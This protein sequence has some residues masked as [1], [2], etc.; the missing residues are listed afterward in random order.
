MFDSLKSLTPAMQSK[1]WKEAV[2]RQDY[3]YPKHGERESRFSSTSV[4]RAEYEPNRPE[5]GLGRVRMAKSGY[6]GFVPAKQCENIHGKTFQDVTSTASRCIKERANRDEPR[7]VSECLVP[8]SPAHRSCSAP[9]LSPTTGFESSSPSV[10]RNPRGTEVLRAGG[11]IP[12]YAGFIPGKAAGGVFG[13][14]VP[15]A[16]MQAMQVRQGRYGG[17]PS[18]SNWIVHGEND[19]RETIYGSSLTGD[20]WRSKTMSTTTSQLLPSGGGWRPYEPLRPHQWLK[21]RR[22]QTHGFPS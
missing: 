9:T 18:N 7:K 2:A 22:P 6:T 4:P 16:N 13:K 14:R 19:R 1:Y 11:A 12:G 10:F 8:K 15:E 20:S 3:T 5:D 17:A 21:E